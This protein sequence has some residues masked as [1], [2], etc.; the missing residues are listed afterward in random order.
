MMD[1]RLEVTKHFLHVALWIRILIIDLPGEALVCLRQRNVVQPIDLRIIGQRKACPKKPL[2][3][4]LK[5]S[6]IWRPNCAPVL[7]VE[8][9][10]DKAD[11]DWFNFLGF[12]A[13]QSLAIRISSV[14]EGQLHGLLEV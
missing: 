11:M 7:R 10:S 8:F 14:S 4:I 13:C 1:L 2:S 6:L 3:F 5:G 9:Q 12:Q